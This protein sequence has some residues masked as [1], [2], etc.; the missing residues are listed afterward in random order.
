MESLNFQTK[1]RFR[2]RSNTKKTFCV[3]TE[4]LFAGQKV[5]IPAHVLCSA[6]KGL[7]LLTKSHALV[8][9]IET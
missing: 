3:N 1:M 2:F 5:I 4:E 8:I 7:Q 9:Y 6:S